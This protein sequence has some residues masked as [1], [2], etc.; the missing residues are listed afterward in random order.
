MKLLCIGRSGQV[1]QAL[2]ERSAETEIACTCLGRPELDLLD[3]DAV[4]AAL[5]TQRPDVVVNA[6]AYTNVDGAES[7]REAA[8]ALNAQA[9]GALAELCA[10]RSLPLIHIS[11]DYVFDGSG[12]TPW[13]EDDPTGPINVYGAS[14][15]AGEIAVRT[16]TEAHI[17]LRTSWVYS[18]FG[19][20][21]A[22]TMLRLA[23]A[24]PEL[25]VVDDQIGAP[26]GALEIADAILAIA[27][28]IQATDALFGTYH[29]AAAGTGSWADFAAEVFAVYENASGKATGL[30]RI[31]TCDYPTPAK[32]PA[33]SRLNT[34][35]FVDAF[36]HTPTYWRG[37]VRA[38]T[39]RLLTEDVG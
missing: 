18:P 34:Q 33:N 22:K 38:V 16:A 30:K 3:S 23:K 27:R 37:C 11:T 20:N 5:D 19:N 9:P 15:L 2:A 35:K 10:E 29:F 6:A 12:T 17:I 21:F 28:Q 8:F 4:A 13:R 36:S 14:K 26:T 31:P 39:E 25:S 1:A 7:D 32:R 24:R